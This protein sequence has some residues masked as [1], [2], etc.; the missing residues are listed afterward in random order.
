[1]NVFDN[2]NFFSKDLIVNILFYKTFVTT[3]LM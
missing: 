3:V 2:F 1:M